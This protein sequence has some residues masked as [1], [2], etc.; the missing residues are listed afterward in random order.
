MADNKLY[1][2]LGVKRNASETEIKK[3]PAD[4]VIS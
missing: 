1:D 2:L 4:V 3:V